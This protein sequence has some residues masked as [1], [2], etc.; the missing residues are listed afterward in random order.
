LSGD[1]ITIPQRRQ[2][3]TVVGNL[4]KTS[5][6]TKVFI[7][8]LALKCLTI[9]TSFGQ[10]KEIKF[11]LDTTITIM[12]HNAVNRDKVDWKKIESNIYTEAVKKKCL[13]TRA[14]IQIS[15]SITK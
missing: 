3:G 14:Y 8:S 11:L 5:Q 2:A 6:M 7:I 15:F 1:G 9:C 12:K 13:S 10:S 4:T